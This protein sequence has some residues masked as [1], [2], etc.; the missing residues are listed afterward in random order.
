MKP[1]VH[2]GKTELFFA[3]HTGHILYGMLA[4]AAACTAFYMFRLYF[5]VFEGAPR[6]PSDDNHGHAHH[7]HESPPAMTVVLWI[8]AAGSALVGLLGIPDTLVEGGDRFGS[9]LMPV[10]MSQARE[11]S[12]HEFLL[13]G[14]IAT[15]ISACGIGLAWLLYGQGFSKGVRQF[16]AAVPRLYRAVLN[17]Y[18]IDEI[19][20][21]IVVRPLRW[22]AFILWKAV[23]SF[24]IDLLLVN[25]AAFLVTGV[26]K[27]VKYVQNGDVQ[28]Y[29]VGLLLGSAGILALA[30]NYASWNA[31]KFELDVMGR[32]VV[33]RSRGAAAA[34]QLEYRVDWGDG[35]P[36]K[37]QRGF[38]F[39]HLY[40]SAGGHKVTLTARDLRWN[41]VWD[42]THHVVIK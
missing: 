39:R 24:I 2:A 16:V 35:E 15:A 12:A 14:G 32:E 7:P 37:P 20:D 21:T 9:W 38:A 28:R 10:V 30:T 6:A 5:L 34:K 8:L 25:G 1:S 19:Y 17:K 11:E 23:D 27:L 26:G 31:S 4:A 36:V 40:N 3:A 13:L 33:L 18:Y 41:T 29:V 42:H 22:I